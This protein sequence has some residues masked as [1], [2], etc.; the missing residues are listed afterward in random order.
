MTA[1]TVVRMFLTDLLV[2]HTVNTGDYHTFVHFTFHYREA[3]S[4]ARKLDV[5]VYGP[6]SKYIMN[7]EQQLIRHTLLVGECKIHLLGQ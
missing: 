7:E 2:T 5:F 4:R 3:I 6:K 1:R